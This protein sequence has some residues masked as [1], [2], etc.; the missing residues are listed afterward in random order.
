MARARG[1][2]ARRE[3]ESRVREASRTRAAK[4]RRKPTGTPANVAH[5]ADHR[6][7]EFAERDVTDSANVPGQV[8]AVL[9]FASPASPVDYLRLPIHTLEVGAFGTWH[10]PGTGQG[11][12]SAILAGFHLGAVRR[13]RRSI[14][15]PS[16]TGVTSTPLGRVVDMMRQSVMPRH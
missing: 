6:Y 1:A 3:P 7:F 12:E 13:P 15:S 4:R 11:E 5:L 16:I 9:H 8:D 14:H 10:A 2:C